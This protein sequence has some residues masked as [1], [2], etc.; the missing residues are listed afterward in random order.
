MV[1]SKNDEEPRTFQ[2]AYSREKMLDLNTSPICLLRPRC[3][4]TVVRNL[5]ELLRAA[6]SP[7]CSPLLVELLN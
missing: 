6:P 4:H 7:N 5:P 2:C 3:F 1:S